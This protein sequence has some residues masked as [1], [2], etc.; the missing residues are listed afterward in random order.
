MR[1]RIA[2]IAALALTA[3]AALPIAARA[4]EIT[5]WEHYDFRG[6]ST[7]IDS[8]NARLDNGWNDRISSLRVDSGTWEVCRDWDYRNCRLVGPGTMAQAQLE[9]GWNDAISSLRPVSASSAGGGDAETVAQRLYSG[10]LGRDADP[11]GLRNAAAQIRAGR[12]NDLVAGMTQSQEFRSIAQQRSPTE[13]LDQIYRGLLG[14][15]ADTAAR[16]AYLPRLQRGDVNNVV[17]D[18]VSSEEFDGGTATAGGGS[19]PSTVTQDEVRANGTGVVI[20]GGK[21]YF[22]TVTAARVQLASNGRIRIS[23]SGSTPQSLDGT[24]TRESADFIR[25]DTI[26]V[27]ERGVMQVDGGV[28]LDNNQLER[29]DVSAGTQGTRDRVVYNFVSSHYDLPSEERLCQEEIQARLASQNRNASKLAFL[30]PE[31]SRVASNRYRLSGEVVL[32]AENA[33][34]QYRCEVDSRGN[35]LLDASV[36]ASN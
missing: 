26:D 10:L 1:I 35:Q 24:Y 17:L 25:V 3:V 28:Q 16:T 13:L 19:A 2:P 4:A 21:K 33:S 34:A 31:R 5:V 22:D 14:R 12:I 36:V 32:L 27:P 8:A 30:A 29:V 6:A 23:F 9:S 11:E 7:V 15:A 20:W 18:I